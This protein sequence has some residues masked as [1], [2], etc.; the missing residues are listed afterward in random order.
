MGVIRGICFVIIFKAGKKKLID[1]QLYL[2][3]KI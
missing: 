3:L 1:L 2:G